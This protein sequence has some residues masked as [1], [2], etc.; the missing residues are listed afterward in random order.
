MPTS[1]APHPGSFAARFSTRMRTGLA[2]NAGGVIV[3]RGLSILSRLLLAALLLP[4]HF[5]M[6][7]M[8]SI[9]TTLAV[10]LM[11]AGLQQT[12]IQRRRDRLTPLLHASAFWFIL[13][14]GL[15]WTVAVGAL[16]IPLI[17]RAFGAP[18]IMAPGFALA[19]GIALQALGT[20]PTVVLTRRMRFRHL[21][22]AEVSGV[23]AGATAA[24]ALAMAGAGI[25]SL[26]SQ[27]LIATAISVI[28]MWR[29][30]SWRPRLRFDGL[31]LR[32]AA[33][34][35]ASILGAR[36]VYYL[37]THL[38]NALVGG[39]LGATALG[40]YSTAFSL[41]EGVR[42]QLASIFGRVML[43]AYSRSQDDPIALRGHYLAMLRMTTVTILPIC[44]GG[45]LFAEPLVQAFFASHWWPAAPIIQILSV[46][47]VVFSLMGP[48]VEV[49][50][51]TGR[52]H[53]VLRIALTNLLFVALPGIAVGTL[54]FGIEGTAVGFTFAFAL[55]RAATDIA[56]RRCIGLSTVLMAREI[57]P[58]LLI[59]GVILLGWFIVPDDAPVVV[60]F[61]LYA[62]AFTILVV[63]YRHISREKPVR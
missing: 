58:A 1:D 61:A 25:W 39:L 38:D 48:S 55:Q 53:W 2:W 40:L 43:P 23:A 26:I 31:A 42:S 34:Y 37:R 11:D 27:Y 16:G 13:G 52:P 9:L 15:A 12:L 33:G 29:L 60:Q 5:G 10:T 41:T 14:S 35:S 47:G 17:A 24:L 57:V 54:H 6:V 21:V 8:V 63:W 20:V 22:A 7:A 59:T 49:L 62:G 45:F 36:L 30:C 44:L 51:A 19:V 50:Q 3:S 56:A 32:S 46:G 4:E 28:L 18:E